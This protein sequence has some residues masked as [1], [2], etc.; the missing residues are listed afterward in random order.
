M[1]RPPFQLETEVNYSKM[2]NNQANQ[3]MNFSINTSW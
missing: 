3:N 2:L 1:S